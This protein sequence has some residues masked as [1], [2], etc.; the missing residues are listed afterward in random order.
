MN[1]PLTP[2]LIQ[3]NAFLNALAPEGN[4][5]FQTFDDNKERAAQ[6][7]KILG[8]DPFAKI[9]QGPLEKHLPAL[10]KLQQE[11][12]GVFFMMNEGDGKGRSGANVLRVR[13][14]VLDLDGAPLEPA[15]KSELP[16]HIVVESSPDKRHAS[17]HWPRA[18]KAT[19]PSATY[20]ASCACQASGTRRTPRSKPVSSNLL[21][22]V[23]PS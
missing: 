3:A 7:K 6:N 21:F 22:K 4:R 10:A 20:R 11:Q 9:F 14:H 23:E 17:T 5:T 16:P 15:V 18:S 1:S 19:W 2:D 13:A 8:Y 12:A